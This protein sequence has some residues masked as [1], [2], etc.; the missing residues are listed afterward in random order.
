MTD[1]IDQPTRNWNFYGTPKQIVHLFHRSS[2]M[3]FMILTYQQKDSDG[4]N[5]TQIAYHLIFPIKTRSIFQINLL[6]RWIISK[7]LML[8]RIWCG[9]MAMILHSQMH[10][11]LMDK[12]ISLRSI[13][14]SKKRGMRWNMLL[15]VIIFREWTLL[16][17]RIK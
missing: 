15:L 3:F 2:C 17:G 4:T 5:S 1:R 12:L 16:K 11:T 14:I 8:R 10:Y 9:Y 6:L 13:L 7:K